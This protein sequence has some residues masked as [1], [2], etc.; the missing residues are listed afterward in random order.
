MKITILQRPGLIGKPEF[1]TDLEK[2]LANI[3]GSLSASIT[4]DG[5]SE[6]GW[7]R[8]DMQGDDS[9]VLSEL[10]SRQLGRA[11]IYLSGIELHEVYRGVVIGERKGNLG[12]D[13]GI[14]QPRPINLIVKEDTLRAQ[15]TDGKTL[16]LKE[17]MDHYC[18]I[19]DSSVSVRVTRLDL[20]T[21]TIEGWLSD[22]QIELFSDW[23]T[24]G[25]DRIQ[26]FHCLPEK[27]AT[28][29]RKAN[30]ER[31][32]IATEPMSL[33]AHSVVCKIGTDAAG[34]IPKLGSILRQ[35]KLRPFLPHR[36]IARCRPW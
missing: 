17:I 29:I 28:A 32:V 14:E 21:G 35:S 25:L 8:V 24:T 16:P 20:D 22:A 5:F 13:L 26:V 30:L 12:V 9:E 3:A 7:T 36:I 11:Q 31:D 19:A 33:T 2:T 15:L 1:T 18:L 10:I 6:M 34:L 4:L 23:I 27:V